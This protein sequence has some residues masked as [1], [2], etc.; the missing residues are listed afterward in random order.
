MNP[1]IEYIFNNLLAVYKSSPSHH[2][3]WGCTT[4]ANA[5]GWAN[6]TSFLQLHIAHARCRSWPCTC[7][8]FTWKLLAGTFRRND[9]KWVTGYANVS[10]SRSACDNGREWGWG[11]SSNARGRHSWVMC[12]SVDFLARTLCKCDWKLSKK[13]AKV[14]AAPVFYLLWAATLIFPAGHAAQCNMRQQHAA[15]GLAARRVGRWEGLQGSPSL[16]ASNVTFDFIFLCQLRKLPSFHNAWKT[17]QNGAACGTYERPTRW[18]R[19]KLQLAVSIR[20]E[21]TL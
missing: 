14:F 4:Y 9:Y 17:N 12:F 3:P 16:W 8:R 2:H 13:I 11:S 15:I 19:G 7:Y 20:T 1:K 18:P 10:F 21:N 6:I 5:A